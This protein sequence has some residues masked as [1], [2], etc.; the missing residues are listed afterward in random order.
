MDKVEIS[1]ADAAV[2]AGTTWSVL[3][4]T[5]SVLLGLVVLLTRA[6]VWLVSWFAIWPLHTLL[7]VVLVI[8]SPVIWTIRF[9]LAP[10]IYLMNK[11]PNIEPF[12]IYFGSA[13]FVGIVAGMVLQLTSSTVVSVL[14]IDSSNQ[15]AMGHVKSEAD[16]KQQILDDQSSQESDWPWLEEQPH[17]PNF[18]RK[19]YTEGL[20]SQTILEEDDSE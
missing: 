20:L 2:W 1:T 9:M 8:I 18:R 13:A 12:Y 5:F 17:T 15:E 3:S 11:M 6:V 7:G 14:G 4:Q 10:F 19:R 16:E